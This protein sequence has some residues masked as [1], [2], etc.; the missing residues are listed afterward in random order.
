[1]RR[2]SPYLV[3]ASMNLTPP[4]NE[5]TRGRR[6][7]SD[8]CLRSSAGPPVAVSLGSWEEDERAATARA[9]AGPF[10]AQTCQQRTP[11]DPL[12]GLRIRRCAGTF[13][14]RT[15]AGPGKHRQPS[16]LR[17]RAEAPAARALINSADWGSA[18]PPEVPAVQMSDQ[19]RDYGVHGQRL[20]VSAGGRS[21]RSG[22]CDN[23]VRSSFASSSRQG[24]SGPVRTWLTRAQQI[25]LNWTGWRSSRNSAS[26]SDR[27]GTSRTR[28]S[29]SSPITATPQTSRR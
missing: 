29:N 25:A 6:H 22:L 8:G 7:L 13:R 11:P 23:A 21:L 2:D 18:R 19:L 28:A 20:W 4:R 16:T 27:K 14:L 24:S 12:R 26:S 1:M 9:C 15:A 3:R 10:R 17:E 5:R